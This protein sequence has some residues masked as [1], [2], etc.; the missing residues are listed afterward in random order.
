MKTASK[1]DNQR[2][3]SII[4]ALFV[5]VVLT[6][7]AAVMLDVVSASSESVAR[8]V[9]STRALLFAESGAQRR[10]SDIFNDSASCGAC[11]GSPTTVDYGGGGNWLGSCSA[12]V[13]CCSLAPGDGRTYYRI[14]SQGHCGQGADRATRVIEVQARD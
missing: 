1:R 4:T 7:L 5:L 3:A 8:E 2:G 11:S 13:S 12:T 10:L 9:T 14:S 6:L